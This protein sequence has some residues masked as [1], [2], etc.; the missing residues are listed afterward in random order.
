MLDDD[1]DSDFSI[2]VAD[3]LAEL[4]QF[5]GGD[6]GVDISLGLISTWA[7]SLSTEMPTI[8]SCGGE[9]DN[10]VELEVDGGCCGGEGGDGIELETDG[11]CC[12]GEGGD[13]IELEAVGGCCGGEG[14]DGIELE[15]VGGCG[16]GARVGGDATGGARRGSNRP[17]R[18]SGTSGKRT[19]Q[20]FS[21]NLSSRAA[22]RSSY[23]KNSCIH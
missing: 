9:G 3:E 15:A 4:A 12:G 11:G 14:G 10:G 18:R 16:G 20:R 13:G 6:L 23:E 19:Q 1:A 2:G 5:F 17:R 22:A 8:T 21:W 7:P